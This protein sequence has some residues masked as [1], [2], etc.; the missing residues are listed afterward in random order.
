MKRIFYIIVLIATLIVKSIS[1]QNIQ[2]ID[3]ITFDED[4]VS[5]I[6]DI[7]LDN[8]Q[9]QNLLDKMQQFYNATIKKQSSN[10][11]YKNNNIFIDKLL[12]N[13]FDIGFDS[14]FNLAQIDFDHSYFS[15][16][17]PIF[18]G[19]NLGNQ[20]P[21]SISFM[22][23]Q[24]I[25]HNKVE[26]VNIDSQQAIT[27][28]QQSQSA[29]SNSQS[30]NFQD[31]DEFIIIVFLLIAIFII[32]YPFLCVMRNMHQFQG[33]SLHNMIIFSGLTSLLVTESSIQLY[34]KYKNNLFLFLNLYTI[35]ILTAST[36]LYYGQSGYGLQSILFSIIYTFLILFYYLVRTGQYDKQSL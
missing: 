35:G 6:G 12:D 8:C 3:I 27:T 13:T 30:F 9:T 16:N 11:S 1:F 22:Q 10:Y 28:S 21:P 7:S 15:F 17:L 5:E 14:F 23:T 24:E 33:Y 34:N 26:I 29:S 2:A 18:E 25:F 31:G 4:L 36:S 20:V 19:A 32:P